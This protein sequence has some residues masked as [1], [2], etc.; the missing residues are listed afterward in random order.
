MRFLLAGEEL[1][2]KC[3]GKWAKTSTVDARSRAGRS[4]VL[5]E[6]ESY[7][8]TFGKNGDMPDGRRVSARVW[9]VVSCEFAPG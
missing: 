3:H 8:H 1:A 2:R 9:L 6:M 5:S 4:K 7:I